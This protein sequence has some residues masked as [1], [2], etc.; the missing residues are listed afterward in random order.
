M[1]HAIYRASK[2][3]KTTSTISIKIK[4]E[5]YSIHTRSQAVPSLPYTDRDLIFMICSGM[6]EQC[7]GP[8]MRLLGVRFTISNNETKIRETKIQRTLQFDQ[9]EKVKNKTPDD[10]VEILEVRISPIAS[11]LLTAKNITKTKSTITRRNSLTKKEVLE[12]RNTTTRKGTPKTNDPLKGKDTFMTKTKKI[13]V[14]DS[15]S[16]DEIIMEL[17]DGQ[18]LSPVAKRQRLSNS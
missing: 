17:M 15:M 5:D 16:E 6:L 13:E 4:Y 2:E 12:T 7:L 3:S 11:D 8:A 10:D 1:D 14:K 18:S 9:N